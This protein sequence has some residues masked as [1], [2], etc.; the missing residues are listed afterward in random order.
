MRLG[1]LGTRITVHGRTLLAGAQLVN[2]T[3]A[4]VVVPVKNIALQSDTQVVF[5]APQGSNFKS[6][7]VRLTSSNGA[8]VAG[9]SFVYGEY[10]EVI[11]VEPKLGAFGTRV[12]IR[13]SN[14]LLGG[15]RIASVSLN[16]VYVTGFLANETSISFQAPRGNAGTGPIR[17]ESDSGGYIVAS[18][19]WTFLVPPAVFAASPSSGTAG[20]VVVLYGTNLRGAGEKVVRCTFAGVEA[21]ILDESNV[22]VRVKAPEGAEGSGDIR[23]WSN[24]GA[25]SLLE[26]GW[27]FLASAVVDRVEPRVGQFGT[28]ITISG[29][30]LVVGTSG[31]LSVTLDGVEASIQHATETGIILKAGRGSGQASLAAGDIVVTS[32]TLASYTVPDAFSYLNIGDIDVVL[33]PSGITG[34]RLTLLG[35]NLLAGGSYL[36]RATL[37]GVNATILSATNRKVS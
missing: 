35:Q 8:N 14:L 34:T 36:N 9:G 28:T 33:P 30:H 27:R 31:L 19:T 12:E 17:I 37:V 5:A 29:Q 24:D 18:D 1:V 20:T 16:S 2:V 13:G 23:L 10:G 26:D 15:S 6:G 7:D 3:L 32:T 25:E 21:E 22:L 11:S 4:E